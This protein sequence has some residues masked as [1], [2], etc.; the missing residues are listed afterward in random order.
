MDFSAEIEMLREHLT[1][2]G[3]LPL[4]CVLSGIVGKDG[5]ETLVV[6]FSEYTPSLPGEEH[7]EY[8]DTPGTI[9]VGIKLK[10]GKIFNFEQM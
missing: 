10:T 7:L 6:H 3:R 2:Q 9:C 5:E 8:Y 1:Q 4:E